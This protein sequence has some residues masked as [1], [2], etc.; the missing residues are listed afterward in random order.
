MTIRLAAFGGR[1]GLL[2]RSIHRNDVAG[3][4]A[5]AA[6]LPSLAFERVT[7]VSDQPPAT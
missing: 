2:L 6:P 4:E 7:V 1:P 3:D 5:A